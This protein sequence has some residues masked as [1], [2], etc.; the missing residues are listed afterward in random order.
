MDYKNVN[1]L[2]DM[3]RQTTF[4]ILKYLHHGHLEKVYENALVS[5]LTKMGL[6]VEHQYPLKVKDQDG[7]VIGEYIADL[8]IEDILI[9]KIKAC[10]TI[11][12]EHIAQI[13]RYLR[14]S[15]IEHDL[16]IN[17]GSSKFQNKKYILN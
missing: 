5:R 7:T 3:I 8:F 17:F 2:C 11:A 15:N 14:A 4:D 13:L 10:K 16:L 1:D 12:D 6:K 9:I